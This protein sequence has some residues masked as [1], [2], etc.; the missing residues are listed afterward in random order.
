VQSVQPDD[1]D[2]TVL[3]ALLA[4]L[5][6]A[7][8]HDGGAGE[9][10]LAAFILARLSGARSADVR[11]YTEGLGDIDRRCRTRCGRGFAH[12]P[13]D[14][15]DTVLTAIEAEESHLPPWERGSAFL[16]TVLRDVREGMF[17]DPSYGGNRNGRGWD[18]LGYPDPRPVWTEADQRLDVVIIPLHPRIARPPR[19]VSR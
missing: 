5:V 17:G 8:E 13:D 6:P 12:A 7:D 18:I 14:E 2:V 15:R 10:G 3:E 4:R 19:E 9:L 1:I 16:E 11:T